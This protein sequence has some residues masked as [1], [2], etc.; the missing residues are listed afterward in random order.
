M[1]VID[2]IKDYLTNGESFSKE[3]LVN[4]MT[5]EA[6]SDLHRELQDT[7]LMVFPDEVELF[8]GDDRIGDLES[9]AKKM[10]DEMLVRFLNVLDSFKQSKRDLNGK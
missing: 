6:L 7:D 4:D 1:N 5:V 9:M 2:E 3:D 10:Y 8:W